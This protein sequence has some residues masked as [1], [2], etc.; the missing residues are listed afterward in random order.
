MVPLAPSPL[1][2]TALRGATGAGLR[3]VISLTLL[4]LLRR[5]L[6]TASSPSVCP[7]WAVWGLVLQGPKILAWTS[8]TAAACSLM[9]PSLASARCVMV[10]RLSSL[11]LSVCKH[12]KCLKPQSYGQTI[13]DVTLKRRKGFFINQVCSHQRRCSLFLLVNHSSL[14]P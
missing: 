1:L 9:S 12:Q 6:L 13:T 2:A 3:P 11:F 14:Y 8:R 4:H 10:L 5:Y 7:V